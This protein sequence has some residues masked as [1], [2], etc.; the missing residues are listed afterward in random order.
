M[1]LRP[2]QM[3]LLV[4][5]T[6]IVPLGIQCGPGIVAQSSQRAAEPAAGDWPMH[7][8]DVFNSR[9][10]ELDQITRDNVDDLRLQWTYSLPPGATVGSE[11][12]LVIDGVMYF[13]S[14]STL[15]ALDAATG[16]ER[17]TTTMA[18]EFRGGGRGP[19]FANGRI[20]AMGQAS[21]FAVDATTGEP[22]ESF[23]A[24]GVV[25]I[26]KDAWTSRIRTRTPRTSTRRRSATRF[27]R[28]RHMLMGR[29]TS[30]RPSRTA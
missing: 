10:S 1:R 9:Y 17:W 12:P 28:R 3:C 18:P 6:S 8:R 2:I 15:F 29:S 14:G 19:V 24:G 21:L 26:V 27:R 20:Y 4:T 25:S 7:N 23:G 30:A 13:N 16:E 22:V 5:L 11:T